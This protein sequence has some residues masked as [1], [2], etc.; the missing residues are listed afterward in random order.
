MPKMIKLFR[1]FMGYNPDLRH[2]KEQLPL[3]PMEIIYTPRPR[4]RSGI[5]AFPIDP[6]GFVRY[7]IRENTFLTT[8]EFAEVIRFERMHRVTDLLAFQTSLFNHLSIP[9]KNHEGTPGHGA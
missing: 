3:D 5:S 4:P 9:L 1:F 7:V 8:C 2:R 6:T